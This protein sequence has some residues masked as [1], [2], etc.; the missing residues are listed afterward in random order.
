M[1]FILIFVGFIGLFT[2]QGIF[3]DDFTVS[4]GKDIFVDSKGHGNYITIQEAIDNASS[5]DTIYVW[6]GTYFENVIINKTI[7]LIG[8]DTTNTTING[9][10][11][12]NVVDISA[13]FINL[14]GFNITG[15]GIG[16]FAGVRLN[17]VDRCNITD[18]NCFNKKYGIY[19]QS[20][21]TENNITNNSCSN[22]EIGIGL[23]DSSNNILFNN[24]CSNNENIGIRI[25]DS[26]S[27]ELI[28]NDCSIN[29][30]VGIYISGSFD[31]ILKYNICYN[32]LYSDG[33]YLGTSSRNKLIKNTCTYNGQHGIQLW[34]SDQNIFDLN[35]CTNNQFGVTLWYADN[36]K[37]YNNTISNNGNNG[38]MLSRSSY[39]TIYNNSLRFNSNDGILLDRANYNDFS[40]C[41]CTDN[42]YCGIEL[43]PGM[44]NNFY[45]N[46]CSDN[47]YG[48]E[49]W[50]SSFNR[51]E[52]NNCSENNVAMDAWSSSSNI[53]S[54][55][56]CL[57]NNWNS[58]DFYSSSYNLIKNNTCA[59]P[60]YANGIQL[61]YSC[62]HNTVLEN[63]CSNG[64]YGIYIR[65][66]PSN[67]IDRNKCYSNEHGIFIESEYEEQDKS[68]HNTIANNT[69]NSNS[70]TGISIFASLYC[71]IENNSISNNIKGI[72]LH[73][74]S[75]HSLV[76]N[77]YC[78]YNTADIWL[79]D[80]FYNHIDKNNCHEAPN[81]II[82]KYSNENII[83]NNNCSSSLETI[84]LE[85]SDY[86]IVDN[87]TCDSVSKDGIYVYS[88][89]SNSITNN[90]C[91]FN[92]QY[93][94]QL[95]KSNNNNI[96]NNT[97]NSNLF[98][99][100]YSFMCEEDRISNNICNYN[101]NGIELKYT[102]DN[103]IEGNELVENEIG[104][105][106]DIMSSNNNIF[107][108]TISHNLDT[109]IS[110]HEK[111]IDNYLYF[112]M[113]NSNS[114]QAIDNGTNTWNNSYYEGNYWS[115]YKGIDNGANNRSAGDGIGDT[116]IPHLNLDN[117]PFIIPYGWSLPRPPFLL[118]PGDEDLDGT[119]LLKWLSSSDKLNYILQ[120]DNNTSFDS[121]TIVYQGPDL[122]FKFTDKSDGIYYYRVKSYLNDLYSNWSNIVDLVVDHYPKVPKKLTASAW[123]EGNAINISW[124][125]NTHNITKYR[126]FY[127]YKD[128]WMI[129]AEITHPKHTFNHTNLTDG[130]E[131]FY[132]LQTYDKQK[133]YSE[134][135][136]P[137]SC[138]SK[139]SMP[140]EIPSMLR[141]IYITYNSTTLAWNE[142]FD[143]DLVGYNLYRSNSS[144]P[145]SWGE[146]ING[147]NSIKDTIYSDGNLTEGTRYFYVITATDE[148]PNES[149]YSNY[150]EV[151]TYFHYEY[152]QP[153]IINNTLTNFSIPEDTWDNSTINMFQWF[154]DINND[155]LTFYCDDQKH[156]NL[157]INQR[158]G[159][160]SLLPKKDWN[161]LVTLTFFASD[162]IFNVSAN[163]TI[164]ITPVND[165]PGPATIN[166][167][168]DGYRVNYGKQINFKA[169]CSDPDCVYG[170]V[171]TFNWVSNIAG[172]LGTGE[173]LRKGNIPNGEHIITLIV[174]DLENQTCNTS[175]NIS[176][177]GQESP[178]EG[179]NYATNLCL[180]GGVGA[181]IFVII[182][183]L[184]FLFQK[185]K[186]GKTTQE[187]ITQE[188]QKK[189]A[190]KDKVQDDIE[191]EHEFKDE[192]K[193]LY[194]KHD[195]SFKPKK[196]R[197]EDFDDL[198][199]TSEE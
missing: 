144:D 54:N 21:S 149:P 83:T 16:D 182:L 25:D 40:K 84:S 191:K 107:K 105:F 53:V 90:T 74:Y 175:I 196:E 142:S 163:I 197:T 11:T 38:L 124:E 123:P 198:S 157:I 152:P 9:G 133:E 46:N 148:V 65:S 114:Q 168:K 109:G 35:I 185:R 147:N 190:A 4:A 26:V 30:L 20:F 173:V 29:E 153:P 192:Y 103:E 165:P 62:T 121:P 199:R 81:G 95:Q 132:R 72:Y 10:G 106:F 15:S 176:I 108:N 115:D 125:L 122:Q 85:Y 172:D 88:S 32:N 12:G 113:I 82:V 117:F 140:P 86:T 92:G 44:Y 87:N 80:A 1:I 171:L 131:Y 93:G 98:D 146:P 177:L 61:S 57:N 112:N 36:N 8:N 7:T 127:K 28:D 161:G 187:E 130:I 119:Y 155:N 55:N 194:G 94:I 99:G 151:R 104:M 49:L 60:G 2:Y 159:V 160:V 136:E 68:Y 18:I 51:F 45:Y 145:L 56:T 193:E 188:E 154:K 166:A 39:N 70:A 118:D 75:N 69:C 13:D 186:K 34:S 101:L 164:N 14:T 179:D 41:E 143:S 27:N 66:S 134:F 59:N 23:I 128:K 116:E 129:A 17:G 120:E 183:F 52:N 184:H 139:D 47:F 78:S 33:I 174:S 126:L 178:Q 22:N 156:I 42:G 50:Q 195:W 167:P 189:L 58:I 141:V 77:N 158:N 91:S 170:D 97:C 64:Y 19:L 43:T 5:G 181:I 63:E 89:N 31:H 67:I 110:I 48:F 96:L 79:E 100:I 111:T 102:T 71:K 169:N 6:A 150:T 24:T 180:M 138:I 73:E 162:G 135:C 37:F 76:R 3:D 137:V